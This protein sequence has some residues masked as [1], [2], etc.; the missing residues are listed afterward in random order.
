MKKRKRVMLTDITA[1]R[2]TGRIVRVQERRYS[3]QRGEHFVNVDVEITPVMASRI[4]ESVRRI[5]EF[6]RSPS[7]D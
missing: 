6:L 4:A 5:N 3:K 7:D 2:Y 1:E